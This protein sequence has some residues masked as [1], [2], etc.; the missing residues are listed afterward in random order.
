MGRNRKKPVRHRLEKRQKRSR[1]K[2]K[3]GLFDKVTMVIL[4]VAVCVFAFSLYQL[5]RTM[6]P[7][8]SGGKEYDKLKNKAITVQEQTD[9]SGDDSG[10][11]FKVDFDVL[12]QENPDTVAWIRFDEPSIISYPVVKSA[13]NKEYLTK[14]FSA[15]DN[16]LGAIFMDMKNKSDFSDRNTM[17]YGHNLK[18]GGEMFSQLKKYEEESFYKEHPNFYIYTPDGNVATYQIY[19]V[20]VVKDTS[21]GYTY[22]FADDAAF[23]SFLEATKASSLY[24]TGV[25]V[26]NDSQIVTLSTCTREGNDDRTIVHGVRVNVQPAG[27]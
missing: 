24:D 9:D 22:Q 6:V 19:S 5:V 11:T 15:N 21:E 17:I 23:A 27:E 2:K 14:T 26:G 16:K 3:S 13:D 25:E 1:Q 8:Y 10:D 18:V 20:G 12:L 4:V 7:Y